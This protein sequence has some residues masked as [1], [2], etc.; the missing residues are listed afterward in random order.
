MDQ[1]EA[2]R[3]KR[4]TLG[5]RVVIACGLLALIYFLVHGTLQQRQFK[6][7]VCVDFRGASHCST[8]AGGTSSEAIRSAQEIDCS[9]LAS[10]RDANMAC[11]DVTPSSVRQVAPSTGAQ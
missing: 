10:G 8:A 6:Y 5:I 1:H 4:T 3:R 9:Q 7:T 2:D 11:L